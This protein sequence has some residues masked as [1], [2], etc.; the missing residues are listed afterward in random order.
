M[1][2]WYPVHMQVDL[3]KLRTFYILA[4]TKSYTR[5]ADKVY[6]TQSAVSHAIK[7]LETELDYELV[8]R[9]N[10]QF[11]LTRQGEF[12]YRRCQRIFNQIDDTLDQLSQQKD[13]PVSINMGAPVEFGSSVLIKGM[14]PFIHNHPEMKID[15][16]MEPYL[17]EPLLADELDIIVDCI[18]HVHKDLVSVALCREAYAVIASPDY[19]QIH[20]IQSIPDLNRCTLLS[21]DKTLFW[22]RNFINALSED[23]GF[24]FEQITRITNV[25]GIINA[26]LGSFGVGFVPRYTVLNELESGAL[27]ELFPDIEALNDQINIYLKKRNFEKTFFKRLISHIKSIRLN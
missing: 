12:L 24:G 5:C 26:S 1:E 13:H 8:D 15:F 7:K 18:P 25:R 19:V 27:V 2:I 23:A 21:F 22:W 11:K 20:K 17:L 9:K 14:A 3:N 4:G 16:V 6:L 10:R